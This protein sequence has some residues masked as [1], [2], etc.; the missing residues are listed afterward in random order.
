MKNSQL[1]RVK[2]KL[3]RDSFIGRNECLDLPFGE[4]ITRLGSIIHK[5]R[6]QGYIFET[7]ETEH[8]FIYTW[9]NKPPKEEYKIIEENG[10]RRAILVKDNQLEL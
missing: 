1:K 4:K 2:I 8:D 9:K 10:E 3:A 7:K 6:L 5:L